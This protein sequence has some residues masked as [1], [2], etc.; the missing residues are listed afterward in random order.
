MAIDAITTAT[1]NLAVAFNNNARTTGNIAG[2]VTSQ[3]Y[4]GPLTVNISP[5]VVRLA[6]VSVVV[7]G[8]G[9][10]SFYNNSGTVNLVTN[11]LLFVLEPSSPIGI[12]Q[13]GINFSIGLTLVIGSGVSLNCTYSQGTN[14]PVTQ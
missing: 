13:V 10:V 2:Q 14:G 12:T 5:G 9:S 1:Q 4:T 11:Q 7:S 8:S 6:N 3:T